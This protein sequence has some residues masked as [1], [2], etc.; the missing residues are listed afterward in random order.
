MSSPEGKLRRD[1]RWWS[2]T[3][4]RLR[5]DNPADA[6]ATRRTVSRQEGVLNVDIDQLK[7]MILIEYDSRKVSFDQIRS[8]VKDPPETQ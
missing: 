6:E 2:L 4:L 7:R 1:E 3:I 8:I 5:G